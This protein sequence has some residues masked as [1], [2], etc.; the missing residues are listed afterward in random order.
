MMI[1]KY[2]IRVSTAFVAVFLSLVAC[3]TRLPN[4][5]PNIVASI[6]KNG[7]IPITANK[8]IDEDLLA[9]LNEGASGVSFMVRE[10]NFLD[11]QKFSTLDIYAQKRV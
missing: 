6:E 9:L 8:I 7:D 10:F 1:S 3:T 2:K 4:N 5:D 11:S